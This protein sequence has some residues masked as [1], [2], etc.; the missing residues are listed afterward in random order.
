MNKQEFIDTHIERLIADDADV[1]A[2]FG[3]T[4]T[5]Q[6]KILMKKGLEQSLESAYDSCAK[7]YFESGRI[8]R[9]VSKILRYGALGADILGTYLFWSFGGAGFGFKGVG[10]LSNA[11]AEFFDNRR[12]E[13]N[14][15]AEGIERI[16]SKDGILIASESA[17]QIAASY[18]P[19]G[20]EVW[21]FLR[22]PKKFDEKIVKQALYAAKYDFV[23]R[24]G[25]ITESVLP[26]S[27]P[28]LRIVPV[29]NFADP[30]YKKA[31]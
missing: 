28:A 20:A 23:A 7:E 1:K 4:G 17:G 30:E 21:A 24:F 22:G 16:I 18:L 11:G 3:K 2:C 29:S 12:Y 5:E 14:R 8:G 13:K 15:K 9:Y 10:A 27:E 6:E 25:D 31:A 19:I 26:V